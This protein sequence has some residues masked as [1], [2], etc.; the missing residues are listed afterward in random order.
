MSDNRQSLSDLGAALDQQRD[1]AVA[2]PEGGA[3]AYLSGQ[4]SPPS[5][6]ASG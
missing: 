1:A 2:S 5:M 4:V 6:P 3:D